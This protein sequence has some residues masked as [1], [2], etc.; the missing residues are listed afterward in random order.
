MH[1]TTR[2]CSTAVCIVHEEKSKQL[3]A[4]RA[5]P[6]R[7]EANSAAVEAALTRTKKKANFIVSKD[8][9]LL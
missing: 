1:I 6:A 2:A 7:H 3:A 4:E 5:Q 8:L 9:K